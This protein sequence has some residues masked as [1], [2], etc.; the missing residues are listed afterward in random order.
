M[1]IEPNYPV[2]NNNIITVKEAIKNIDNKTF[3]KTGDI[4][5]KKWYKMSKNLTKIKQK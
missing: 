4:L 5:E 3:I 1:N 2:P